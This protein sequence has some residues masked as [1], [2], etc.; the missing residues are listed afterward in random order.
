MFNNNRYVTKGVTS[1]IPEF[2]QSI[3]WYAIDTM[4]ITKKDYLQI[5]E[6]SPT[7]NDGVQKQ[8]IIH[9][10]EQPAYRKDFIITTK[11]CIT[12]KVYVIDEGTH[13]IMLLANEY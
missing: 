1:T 6:L 2:L 4:P 11:E 9:I 8:K 7:I 13:C 3:L 12:T 5:F 10:Q